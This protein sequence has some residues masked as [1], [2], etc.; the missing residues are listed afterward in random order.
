MEVWSG[1]G[2]LLCVHCDLGLGDITLDQGHDTP[3][4]RGQQ[5]IVGFL[6][7]IFVSLCRRCH[8]V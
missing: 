5:Y 8:P 2:Y 7:E 4:G 3:L 1:H 6:C